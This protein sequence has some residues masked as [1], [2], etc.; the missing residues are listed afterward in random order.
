[1]DNRKLR[2]ST[3]EDAQIHGTNWSK[4]FLTSGKSDYTKKVMI[5]LLASME[6]G[7]WSPFALAA[8]VYDDLRA[9]SILDRVKLE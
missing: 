6:S 4:D 3:L 7:E 5:N 9:K 8:K 1:M 2:A